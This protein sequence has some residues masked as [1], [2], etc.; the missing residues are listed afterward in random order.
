[1]QTIVCI[2]WS[3]RTRHHAWLGHANRLAWEFIGGL[4]LDQTGVIVWR[5]GFVGVELGA[6]AVLPVK[7][8][9]VE[10]VL[11]WPVHLTFCSVG[12]EAKER[13]KEKK[14]RRRSRR[15]GRGPLTQHQKRNSAM[16]VKIA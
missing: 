5:R 11:R 14:N 1:M 3:G 10:T 6:M 12:R 7:E 9:I 15:G 2:D 13:K 16:Y 4:V 8:V